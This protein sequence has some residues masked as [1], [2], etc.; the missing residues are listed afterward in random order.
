MRDQARRFITLVDE[1]Y[2]AR[3]RMVCSAAAPPDLLF[4][5]GNMEGPGFKAEEPILDLEQLQ[6]WYLGHSRVSGARA[7]NCRKGTVNSLDRGVGGPN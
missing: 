3:V 2:N 4:T 6:V 1:L 5:G 7:R